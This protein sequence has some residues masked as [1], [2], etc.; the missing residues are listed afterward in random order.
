MASI[1]KRGG[2][3]KTDILRP[4]KNMWWK[5]MP[6]GILKAAPTLV[7]MMMKIKMEWYTLVKERGLKFFE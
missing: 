4:G 6:N 2:A 1:G 7:E 5:V 3:R